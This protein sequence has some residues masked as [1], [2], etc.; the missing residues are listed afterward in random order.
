M[1]DG[2]EYIISDIISTDRGGPFSL[3]SADKNSGNRVGKRYILVL[4]IVVV[5]ILVLIAWRNPNSRGPDNGDEATTW[6]TFRGNNARTGFADVPSGHI[7]GEER[8]TYSIQSGQIGSSPVVSEDGTIYIGSDEYN[9]YA[10]EKDGTLK[11]KVNTGSAKWVSSSGALDLNGIIY[12]GGYGALSEEG[13]L[14]AIAPN[15]SVLWEYPLSDYIG[16]SPLVTSD[17]T[18]YISSN[19]SLMAI[20][21]RGAL[22][23]NY[24]TGWSSDSS[25]ALGRDGSIL[26]CSPIDGSSILSSLT[27]D[28]TLEWETEIGGYVDS[29]PAISSDGT[30]YIGSNDHYLY[31]LYPNGSIKWRF[32]ANSF[33]TASVAIGR[34]GTIYLGSLDHFLYALDIDGNVK[35]KFEADD[36]IYSSPA[37]SRDGIIYF[38]CYDGYLYSLDSKGI[39]RW[40]FEADGPIYSSPTIC[41]D[42]SVTFGGYG[43]LYMIGGG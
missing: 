21:S 30:I 24:T 29:T 41:Q 14:L 1:I 36:A 9:V 11:W 26:I 34:D 31:A 28:G 37:V 4:L 17:G 19:G 13:K 12:F 15:G 27:I 6:S 16:S 23:W 43:N 38:G 8:W 42:G 3:S 39:L 10:I 18:I 5:V 7:T 20:D 25:P 35:W 32:R 22:L 40:K 33:I 2:Y